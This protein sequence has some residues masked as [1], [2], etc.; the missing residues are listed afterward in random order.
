[1]RS[2]QC[3]AGWACSP[4]RATRFVSELCNVDWEKRCHPISVPRPD[5]TLSDMGW[6]AS[7]AQ[8]AADMR[9]VGLMPIKT[10][11]VQI[12]EFCAYESV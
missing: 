9:E 6:S 7:G 1:M 11:A 2:P 8:I 5:G 3:S 12:W 4:E 10:K